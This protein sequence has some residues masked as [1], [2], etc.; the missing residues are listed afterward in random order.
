MR[1]ERRLA[2]LSERLSSTR[3][4]LEIAGEQLAFQTEVA[5][6]TRVRMLVSGTPLSERDYRQAR[7]DLQRLERHYENCRAEVEELS[8]EQDRLLDVLLKESVGN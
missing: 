3:R 7:D 2:T 5:D 6:E 4:D 8:A 1:T